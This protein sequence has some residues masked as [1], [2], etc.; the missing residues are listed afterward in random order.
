VTA[1]RNAAGESGKST[2][3]RTRSAAPKPAE[4]AGERR[5][6]EKKRADSEARKRAREADARRLRIEQL[7][8]RIAEC[9]QAIRAIEEQMSAPNFYDDRAAAQPVID[10]HQA[11][12]WKVGDL[13]HQWE[14]LQ[15][16]GDLA[17]RH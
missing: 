5:R 6:E 17:A 13:M 4:P 7:E 3:H 2:P 14:M 9:E 12:M 16:A 1:R 8:A 11:L 10:Q 15:T